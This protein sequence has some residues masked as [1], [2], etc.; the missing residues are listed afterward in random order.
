M[1]G[2]GVSPGIS[3]GTAQL[4]KKKINKASGIVINDDEG[5]KNEIE[6][7]SNAVSSSVSELEKLKEDNSGSLHQSETDILDSQIEFLM[8]PQI[9]TDV[10]E[11]INI[12]YKIAADAV[13]EVIDSA[14]EMFGN[15]DDD[16]LRERASDIRDIGNRLLKHLSAGEDNQLN[17]LAENT[18]LI[19][20][21]ITPSDII[22]LDLSKIAGFA[23][24]KGGKTSH[25]AIIAR[26]RGIPAVVAC[27][28]CLTGIEN[29]D[30]ILL[31]GT[32]GEVIV[33]PDDLTEEAY[34]KRKK[35]FAEGIAFLENLR[36]LPA[37]T[38]DGTKINLY[39][40]IGGPGDMEKVTGTGGEGIGLLRTE[41]LFMDRDTLPGEDEQYEFYREIT[42]KANQMPVIIRTLDIG[43]DKQLSYLS[44]PPE[45]NPFMGYRAIRLSLDRKDIFITQLK[46]ILRAGCH[47]NLKIMFPMISTIGEVRAAKECLASAKKELVSSGKEFREGMKT[48]IMIEIPAAA[49]MADLLAKEV[50][51]FSIG[52]NDLCQYTLAVDRMNEKV[53]GLYNHFNPAVLRLIAYAIEQGKKNNIHVGLCGEM[54]GDPL[55]T[56][57]L[58]GMGLKEFSMS[59][60]SIPVI[61]NVIRRTNIPVAVDVWNKVKVMSD[62]EEITGF[63]KET[64]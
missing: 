42:L 53:A 48:G 58:M 16:Y 35:N 27:G 5:R 10:L 39:A 12:E 29:N 56:T 9:R 52:T 57:L 19:A 18:I 50:D 40:N 61:K 31:D 28:D 55:A 1:F 24:R 60:S 25:T 32:T 43:G 11:K 45:N 4:I 41:M 26:S 49:V 30:T 37:I 51:F 13:I 38:T 33:N 8:D 62:P 59:A 64:S 2:I 22:A 63:L 44:I 34:R 3:I 46:A 21:D 20:E 17:K 15:I 47:G 14:A 36:D 7:F 23:T 54:A 6:K